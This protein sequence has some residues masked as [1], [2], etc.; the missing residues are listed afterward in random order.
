MCNACNGTGVRNGR[1][2]ARCHGR[3]Q[4]VYEEASKDARA[5]L[6]RKVRE[7]KVVRKEC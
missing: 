1:T 4:D 2:C 5:D 7:G 6:E 3:G